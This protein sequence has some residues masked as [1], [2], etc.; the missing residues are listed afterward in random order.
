MKKFAAF[1]LSITLISVISSVCFAYNPEEMLAQNID[2]INSILE[3]NFFPGDVYRQ[4]CAQ[5]RTTTKKILTTVRNNYSRSDDTKQQI[6]R[7]T[8]AQ[9]VFL[10]TH[11]NNVDYINRVLD[12]YYNL[13]KA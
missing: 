5:I 2:E 10:L 6:M 9:I 13:V 3:E 1:V 11:E 8:V 7:H 4:E 12:D